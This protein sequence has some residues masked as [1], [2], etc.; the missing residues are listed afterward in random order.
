MQDEVSRDLEEEIAEEG[1]PDERPELLTRDHQ[2]LVHRERGE[3]NVNPVE[4]GEHVEHEEEGQ[5]APADFRGRL[6]IE[7]GHLGRQN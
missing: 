4:E 7:R 1:N 2:V 6:A 3:T 5:E